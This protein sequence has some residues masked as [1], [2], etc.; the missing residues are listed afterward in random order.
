MDLGCY[1]FTIQDSALDGICCDWFAGNGKYKLL[2]DYLLIKD[3][4]DFAIEESS[5]LFGAACPSS[6]P[7]MG[8]KCPIGTFVNYTHSNLESKC[9]PCSPGSYQDEETYSEKCK[10][11]DAGTYQTDEG[12]SMCIPCERGSY[13]VAVGQTKCNKCRQGGYCDISLKN[14]CEGGFK[15]C[16]PGTYNKLEGQ[17]NVTACVQC[18]PGESI[19][20]L[21]DVCSLSFCCKFCS[22]LIFKQY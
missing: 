13:Q 10:E 5:I 1:E 3:G 11:C 20:I 15:P 18:P 14:T 9:Q 2:V 22:Q 21:K 7:S 4:G 19:G 17:Y 8:D 16:Q 6:A 12:K